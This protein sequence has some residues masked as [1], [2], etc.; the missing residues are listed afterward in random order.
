MGDT[1]C[2]MV[3]YQP[4]TRHRNIKLMGR[5]A[6]NDHQA[7]H[8]MTTNR[9][10]SDGPS[11]RVVFPFVSRTYVPCLDWFLPLCCVVSCESARR[12]NNGTGGNRAVSVWWMVMFS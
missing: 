11:L 12:E 9:L 8:Q 4:L 6:S 3:G 1:G 10:P 2:S 5:T 7:N